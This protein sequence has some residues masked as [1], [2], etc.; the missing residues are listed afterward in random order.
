M[1]C[2]DNLLYIFLAMLE[3]GVS[4]EFRVRIMLLTYSDQAACPNHLQ[5]AWLAASTTSFF[6]HPNVLDYHSIAYV[7]HNRGP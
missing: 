1:R 6:G 5:K 3:L 4:G 2:G 7:T